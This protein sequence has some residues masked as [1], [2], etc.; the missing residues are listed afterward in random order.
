MNYRLYLIVAMV[1]FV[2]CSRNKNAADNDTD[3][4]SV[5][6]LWHFDSVRVVSKN[7]P[8]YIPQNMLDLTGKD[9][10]KF[11]YLTKKENH[12]L[13]A[14]PYQ[15]I[16]DTVYVNR[17]PAYKILKLNAT[18]LDLLNIFKNANGATAPVADSVI[19]VYKVK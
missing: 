3:S 4:V 8:P 15:L 11:S 7:P 19:M 13:T 18:E 5:H 2:G 14:Y 16:H 1:L 12:D 10:L 17:N 9:T 6:K